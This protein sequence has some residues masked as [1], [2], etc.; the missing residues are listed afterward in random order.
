MVDRISVIVPVYNNGPWLP[1]CL[2]SLSSQTYDDLE[3]IVVND[4]STDDSASIIAAFCEKSPKI[5]GVHQENQGVTAARLRGLAE[6]SGEWIGFVDGDDTIAPTMYARLLDNAKAYAADISHCG[7]RKTHPDGT[8]EDHGGSGVIFPQENYAGLRELLEGHRIEPGLCTKLFR[9]RLFAGLEAWMDFSIK[10]NED[11][12]MNF[13]L[14]RQAEKTVFEDSCLYYYRSRPGSA[15]RSRLNDH[16]I[17]DPIRVRQR[18]LTECPPEF[19][20]TAHQALLRCQLYVYA[21]LCLEKEKAFSRQRR[22][23][24]K[25]IL[26]QRRYFSLL[27]PRNQILCHMV[28]GCPWLF[29]IAFCAYVAIVRRGHYE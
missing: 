7:Y 23:V 28:C 14:F 6:A 18:I 15:S 12:L 2:E 5:K 9:R 20:P 11:L 29:R 26:D 8:G 16:R 1:Q 13:Y 4:G 24:R 27:S 21:L 3:I 22:N 25:G 10:N 19:K 17:H